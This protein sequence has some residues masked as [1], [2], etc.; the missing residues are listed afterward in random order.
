[1]IELDDLGDLSEGELLEAFEYLL[2]ELVARK[3]AGP[4]VEGMD[5][6]LRIPRGEN[7]KSWWGPE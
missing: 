5:G 2:A 1:V 4:A 7:L 3:M 6:T